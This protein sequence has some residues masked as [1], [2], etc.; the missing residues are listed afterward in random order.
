MERQGNR[1]EA[2]SH[3]HGKEQKDGLRMSHRWNLLSPS[4][5]CTFAVHLLIFHKDNSRIQRCSSPCSTS[6]STSLLSKLSLTP[7]ES[8]RS[9]STFRIAFPD[10]QCNF[11]PSSPNGSRFTSIEPRW[12]VC[13]LISMADLR[14]A[15]F[16]PTRCKAFIPLSFSRRGVSDQPEGFWWRGSALFSI[17]STWNPCFRRTRLASVPVGPPP[18]TA[19]RGS[20]PFFSF[21]LIPSILSSTSSHA[22]MCASFR[23]ATRCRRFASLLGSIRSGLSLSTPLPLPLSPTPTPRFYPF[24]RSDPDPTVLPFRSIRPRPHGSTL[25]IGD[26]NPHPFPFPP[27]P[28]PGGCTWLGGGTR[29]RAK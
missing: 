7:A 5:R 17:N 1:E 4:S 27:R 12:T 9:R 6:R 11:S 20:L 24:N 16:A 25:S 21:P 28:G 8:A 15:S 13:P 29:V 14:T 22:L 26:T 3:V 18:T 19:A 23:R 10:K 2:R